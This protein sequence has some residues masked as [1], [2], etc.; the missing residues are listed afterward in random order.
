MI[1]IK[2][3]QSFLVT[4]WVKIFKKVQLLFFKLGRNEEFFFQKKRKLLILA[5]VCLRFKY[6]GL[7]FA[8]FQ[9]F[10]PG[11]LMYTSMY[12]FGVGCYS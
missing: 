3:L 11:P 6:T 5:L 4:Q 7:F 2:D 8:L 10:K 1:K 9:H 12:S